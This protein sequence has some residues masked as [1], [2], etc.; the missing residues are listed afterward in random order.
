MET[1]KQLTDSQKRALELIGKLADEGKIEMSEAIQLIIAIYENEKEIVYIPYQTPYP[2]PY[3]WT[4]EPYK[5]EPYKTPYTIPN[6]TPWWE[7]NKII[8][9]DA[10]H[11]YADPNRININPYTYTVNGNGM[12]WGPIDWITNTLIG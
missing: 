4:I 9:D 10:N 2:N 12:S 6:S 1:T 11:A 8:C 5:D 3:P 7:K